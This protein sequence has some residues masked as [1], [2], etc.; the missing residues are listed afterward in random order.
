MHLELTQSRRQLTP[1]QQA[2]AVQGGLALLTSIS[3]LEL[4][5]SS[6]LWLTVFISVD[7]RSLPARFRFLLSRP[8]GSG[9]KGHGACVLSLLSTGPKS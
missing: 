1:Y 3:L 8:C 2:C 6:H 5:A 9:I 7:S 4:R